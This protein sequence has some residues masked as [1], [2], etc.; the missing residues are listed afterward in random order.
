LLKYCLFI[1]LAF[2]GF[3]AI[4]QT[5]KQV[6][7]R[8][9]A[10]NATQ[11]N[12]YW[13]INNLELLNPL[14]PNTTIDW[15]IMRTNM[16]KKGNY[17]ECTVA[18]PHQAYITHGFSLLQQY[19]LTS[20]PIGFIDFNNKYPS[21]NYVFAADTATTITI[22]PNKTQ[23]ITNSYLSFQKF[24][25]LFLISNILF[26]TFLF[27]LPTKKYKQLLSPTQQTVRWLSILFCFSLLAFSLK[28]QTTSLSHFLLAD[29]NTI[30]YPLLY[31]T[32]ADFVLLFMGA[33]ALFVI[34]NF[35]CK[36]SKIPFC[37]FIA[38]S[39]LILLTNFLNG[40][41]YTVTGQLFNYQWLYYASFFGTK[42]TTEAL[43]ANIDFSI[44][45]SLVAF[46]VAGVLLYYSIRKLIAAH[47]SMRILTMIVIVGLWVLPQPSQPLKE[48][49]TKNAIIQ[50]I[51]SLSSSYGPLTGIPAQAKEFIVSTQNP[52]QSKPDSFPLFKN[53]IVLVLES[54]PS[55]YLTVYD[56]SMATTPFLSSIKNKTW[57]FENIYA[58]VPATNKSMESLLCASFPYLSF[59]TITYENP[60][61]PIP[62]L[63]QVLKN[64]NYRT[65]FFSSGDT[66]YLN[67]QTFLSNHGFDKITDY[68]SINSKILATQ[69]TEKGKLSGTTD[70]ALH[71]EI[72]GW[73][74]QQKQQ[75]FFCM[76]WTFQTH[77]PYFSAGK[78]Q[79]NT[80]NKT[81]EKYLNAIA[82]ADALI[83]QLYNSLAKRNLLDSTLIVV[84]GDHGEAFGE[85]AQT[86]HATHIYEENVHIPLLF[87]HTG[88]QQQ[89][90][91]H[92]FGAISDIAPTILNLLH[93]AS[94]TTW[95]GES[96]FNPQKRKE[97][98]LFTPYG[99]VQFG[100]IKDRKKLIINDTRNSLAWYNLQTD[101]AEIKNTIQEDSI[102]A[103]QALPKLQQW[104]QYQQQWILP[105]KKR[106]SN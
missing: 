6:T 76:G 45:L 47:S 64:N 13:Y 7:I 43:T 78:K 77:Y 86:T 52:F 104:I 3:T 105:Y 33:I 9:Y 99:D 8:Y 21:K 32:K 51:Q 14:P 2:I 96:L 28:L 81:K 36:N 20:N 54:V 18:L 48:P 92:T 79:F 72:I 25:K 44:A 11:A 39:S 23:L 55:K 29:A 97:V 34:E 46:A 41:F 40:A 102:A 75:P 16:V 35:F 10:P 70:G 68:R 69:E 53:I 73:I 63:P 66:R 26:F 85:H 84:L 12:W 89:K 62:A 31:A 87:I 37:F 59:K 5:D 1:A 82:D 38:Y 67:Q 30:F 50:F 103:Y 83:Q 100:M 56:S 60:N 98:Y 95:Q 93:K 91:I 22:I 90:T 15:H 42:D 57:L 4:G 65:A 61:Y 19:P 80:N 106:L 49:F 17:F 24:S 71:D 94:P 74:D 88:I 58:H 101:P 27:F